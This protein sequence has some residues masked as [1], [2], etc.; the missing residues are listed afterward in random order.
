MFKIA[1]MS[2]LVGCTT[3][4]VIKQPH[5]IETPEAP[6]DTA[7]PLTPTEGA[8]LMCPGIHLPCDREMP[9]GCPPLACEQN[10]AVSS[11]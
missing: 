11:D 6:A 9:E 4:G 7:S 10:A 3:A 1:L 5:I 2:I 8:D